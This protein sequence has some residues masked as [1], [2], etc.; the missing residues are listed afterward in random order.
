MTWHMM[1]LDTQTWPIGEVPGF[2]LIDE[3]ID[4]LRGWIVIS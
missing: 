3:Y 1:T 4:L 2:G